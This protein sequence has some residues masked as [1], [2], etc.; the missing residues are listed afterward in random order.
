MLNECFF[1]FI[2]REVHSYQMKQERKERFAVL[3]F[4]DSSKCLALLARSKSSSGKDTCLREEKKKEKGEK[5]EG[6]GTEKGRSQ[7][8]VVRTQSLFFLS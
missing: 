8:K 3:S 6:T 7:K 4:A 2:P 1:A 5:K